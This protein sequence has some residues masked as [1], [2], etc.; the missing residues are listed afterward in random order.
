MSDCVCV[1]RETICS[2]QQN[3][4][5]RILFAPIQAQAQLAGTWHLS[6]HAFL[7]KSANTDILSPN[8]NP[9]VLKRCGCVVCVR[10]LPDKAHGAMTSM[11]EFEVVTRCERNIFESKVDL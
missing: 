8:A 10:V 6:W 5:I 1:K 4:H 2:V 3:S 9:F 11:T 7:P